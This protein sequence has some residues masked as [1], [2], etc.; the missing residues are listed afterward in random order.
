MDTETFVRSL[1]NPEFV[2]VDCEAIFPHPSG[3]I[4]LLET[5]ISWVLLVGDFAYKFKKPV[6][7]GFVDFSTPES[8]ADACR[9]EVR[10]NRRTAA[11]LYLGV[12]ALVRSRDALSGPPALESWRVCEVE[13]QESFAPEANF[14]FID[15][16]VRMRRFPDGQLMADHLARGDVQAESVEQFAASL[17]SFHERCDVAG[18]SSRWGHVATVGHDSRENLDVLDTFIWSAADEAIRQSL[19]QLRA[20]TESELA[21]IA[22][23]LVDRRRDGRVR[24]CHGDLHLRNVVWL[25]DHWIPFDAIEFN[26][27]LRWNDVASEVA[28]L[29]MDLIANK[30]PD[31]GYRFLNAYI[32][33]SDDHTALPTMRFF[34]AYRS[35]VR[36]KVEALRWSQRGSS[37]AEPHPPKLMSYIALAEHFMMP[38]ARR[39]IITHGVSGSG[40]TFG[41]THCVEA[42][43][44]IRIRS[45]VE[46][47]RIASG[48]DL[49]AREPLYGAAWTAR[50]YDRLLELATV[51]VGA[52]WPV[53]VDATFLRQTDRQRFRELA[54]ELDI[55]FEILPFEAP[56]E[57]LRKRIAAR[58]VRG[59]DA[60]DATPDLIERQLAALD[61]LSEDER[62]CVRCP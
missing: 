36:A 2:L 4:Q 49:H 23:R 55:P 24:E 60:S 48:A 28:F 50:T 11:S 10:L 41:S 21:T 35:L 47:K 51:I 9:E 32:E 58:I 37:R 38:R 17:H 54:S 45:D 53:V 5:H 59:D 29:V 61:P 19:H 33:A 46:R 31:L 1:T 39:L 30:R 40:K 18:E 16:A 8:R 42:E 56:L 62:K 20:W 14:E 44:A 12:V 25:E 57:V 6:S 7:L 34:L 27:S 15:F 22:P 43:G 52:G 13:S 3:E 26:A